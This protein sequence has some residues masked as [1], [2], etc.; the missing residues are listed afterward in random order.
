M[1][2][3]GWLIVI[4]IFS[5]VQFRVVELILLSYGCFIE[6]R[7]VEANRIRKKYDERIPV[8]LSL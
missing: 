5:D 3:V 1:I 4:Y 2:D 8:S 6:R 7:Q